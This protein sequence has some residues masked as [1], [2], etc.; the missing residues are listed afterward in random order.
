MVS[1]PLKVI[2][3]YLKTRYRL[4]YLLRPQRNDRLTSNLKRWIENGASDKGDLEEN[5]YKILKQFSIKRNDLLYR[6]MNRGMIEACK[7]KEE[8]TVL[9]KYNSIVLPQLYQTE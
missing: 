8:D 5:S 4:S 6:G 1:G 3:T 9:Y 7:R 2:K